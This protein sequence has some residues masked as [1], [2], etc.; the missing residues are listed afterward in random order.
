MA[1]KIKKL[2]TLEQLAQFC[3]SN[4]FYSFSAKESGYTL[5]VQVPGSLQFSD[6]EDDDLLYTKIKVC[7]TLL[8]RNNSYISEKNM[9]KAMPTLK[10][11]PLLASIVYDEENDE[12]DFNGHDMTINDDGSIDYI[13]SQIGTFTV[14]EPYLEYDKD[15]DKTY[16]IANA[17]ISKEYTKAASIIERKNGTKVSCELRINEMQ[18]NSKKKYLELTDFVFSGVCCLGEKVG[19]GMLGSRLDI[20][21]F[22]TE[23][24]S[25]HYEENEKLVEVLERLNTT[26]SNFQINNSNR[27]EDEI[28]VE[29]IKDNFEEVTETVEVTETEETT[30]EEVTVTENESEETVDETSEEVVEDVVEENDETV[31]EETTT[32]TV[33]VNESVNTVEY[34]FEINGETKKFA[35]SLQEKIY[36]I[37]DLV[38]ATYAEADNTYYG[39]TV[40]EDYVVMQDWWNGRYFKQSYSADENDN[41]SLTGDRVEVYVEYVT[42]S[43][44]KELDAM[45]SNYAALK[46][47]KENVEKNELTAQKNELINSEKYAVIAEKNEEGKYTNEAF[48]KLV[49]E[50]DNYSLAELETQIKV[51][52]SDFM[53]ENSNFSAKPESKMGSVKVFANPNKKAKPKKRYGN[54]FD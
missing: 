10:Y 51:I 29:N 40:Y 2:L 50:M 20:A 54:L 30:E 21:D 35:V 43:E 46:E 28:E 13:E 41:Y 26:L 45:R 48:A 3:E 11:K 12:Y 49:S 16:V 44:Q 22:S 1:K 15:M 17:V 14:D 23:N 27:K 24:N 18:Y 31:E 52:H 39:V 9:K 32:E 5:S 7:H 37:Q 38:N 36:S 6:K 47:F 34:S 8:N 42:E 4:K 33:E 53:A 19:E 25:F